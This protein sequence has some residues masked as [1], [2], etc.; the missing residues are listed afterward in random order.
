MTTKSL[1]YLSLGLL[2]LS[3]CSNRQIYESVQAD[4][5]RQC[6]RLPE[7]QISECL[8]RHQ[9]TYDEYLLEKQVIEAA[10]PTAN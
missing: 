2:C 10:D 3:A 9:Q 5:R 1:F 6:E 4:Q 7:S 8:A